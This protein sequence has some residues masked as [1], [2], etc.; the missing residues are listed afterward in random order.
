M[1]SIGPRFGFAY[2]PKG[3][4]KTAIRGGFG[5][6]YD[7]PQGNM[8][9]GTNGQPPVAYSPTLY[10]GNLDTFLQAQGAV[11][12]ATV[13]APQ[14]GEQPLPSVMS[15]SLG[16]QR[17]LGFHT[18]VD[19]AYAGGLSRHLIYARNINPIPMFARFDP[20]NLD[21]TT[22]SPMQDN[23]LRPYLGQSNINV[24]GFDATSSYNALQLSV[25][26]R[27][28][29]GMQY[30]MPY[31]FSKSLGINAGDFDAV[32]PYFDMR[33]WN[34]GPLN[35][36]IPHVL[37]LNYAWDLPNPADRWKNK[38]LDLVCGHW[39]ISGIT[40]F[41]SGTPFTPGITTSDGADL[42]GSTETSRITVVS[43][44]H[45][46]KGERTFSRNFAT[47][48]FARTPK[49]SFGNAGVNILR[50]PGVNN[51]DLSVSKR[52]PIT[53][54]RYFQLRGVLQRV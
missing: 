38:A 39:Q 40:T 12:P 49:G 34:Y 17:E 8:N 36:D 42:S 27:M 31:T 11:G 22:N 10:F 45:L 41:L 1:F 2:D 13:N 14:V 25:N 23:F 35:Y 44:P 54:A 32:S 29:K 28:S 19:V 4:G 37:V 16:V 6:F 53:E 18:V 47:E 43:D 52:I 20:A 48:A 33:S 21:P 7:R 50:G 15:F 30:G 24:R 26:R 51:F 3:D 5:I 9:S 46:D